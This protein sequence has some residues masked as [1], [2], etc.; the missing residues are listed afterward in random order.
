MQ[1]LF[2]NA[3][4]PNSNRGK[5]VVSTGFG[6]DPNLQINLRMAAY[7]VPAIRLFKE[8]KL[9]A[10]SVVEF[11]FAENFLASIRGETEKAKQ[12]T[13]SAIDYIGSY[14]NEVYPDVPVKILRD[15]PISA[16][17]DVVIDALANYLQKYG[18]KRILGFVENRGGFES[19]R[20]MASHAWYSRD[21][22][23]Q[24]EK[25]PSILIGSE[26]DWDTIMMI[27][28]RSEEIFHEARQLLLQMGKHDNWKSEQL[29]TRV[30]SS[31]PCYHSGN[32][33]PIVGD[34]FPADV[35]EFISSISDKMIRRDICYL[36]LDS[37]GEKNFARIE[38]ANNPCEDDWKVYQKGWD[39]LLSI[40]Q[41]V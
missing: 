7:L 24:L 10:P 34:Q 33:D 41:Y 37:A 40:V 22:I 12:W 15:R 8:L 28:G 31:R 36:L 35:R 1:N 20:Y 9:T 11:Y 21:P 3:V 38:R 13:D 17:E 16:N 26:K 23:V 32:G 39:R 25:L 18:S 2:K 6:S 30:G 29:F 27:G 5:V 19:L 14:L 4:S